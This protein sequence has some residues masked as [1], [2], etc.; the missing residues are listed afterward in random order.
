MGG[1]FSKPKAPK[2]LPPPPDR[3]GIDAAAAA[4]RTRRRQAGASNRGSTKLGG[5]SDS[6]QSGKSALGS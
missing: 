2:P 1:L 5:S 4:D 3:S 6:A